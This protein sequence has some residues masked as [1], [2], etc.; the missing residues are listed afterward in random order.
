M[1]SNFYRLMGLSL[2]FVATVSTAVPTI[3]HWQTSNG[4]SVYFV[5]TTG[6]PILD[7]QLLF[8]A[9]SVRDDAKSGIAALT[10][11]LLDQ[12]A[13]RKSA[14]D[15]A[16]ALESVGAQLGV[17]TSRD[18]TSI[19]FRSL[20]DTESLKKS[21]AILKKVVNEPDF[22][23][24]DFQREKNR[25][26]LTIAKREESPG[27]LAQLALYKEIFKGHGYA[28]AV[29]GN[30]RTVSQLTADDLK[31]FYDDYYVAQNLKVILVGGVSNE[32]AKDM[33]EDL[34][35]RLPLGEKAATIADVV[36]LKKGKTI[37]REY[38]SQQTHI[39]YSLPVLK[40]NDADYFA[41]YMGNHI[42]GGSGFSSR[43]VKE[44]REQRGLAYSAY[45]Y[46]HPMVEKGPFLVGLQTRNEKVQEATDAIK[47]TLS[48]FIENGPTEEEL[49]A[50]K[51]NLVGG[52]ALKLDSNKK[53]LANV[54][55]I[56]ASGAPLNY[57][58]E[59]MGK[60]KA[61]TRK[62]V[63]DAFERRVVMDKMVMVTV[64]KTVVNQDDGK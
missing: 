8:D 24:V 40:H 17:S 13:A 15:I 39:M 4:V 47:S 41:L 51:K 49:V 30:K 36:D 16:E 11:V 18:F 14:Q 53:L 1:R 58:N 25:T 50:A 60:V 6:L 3:Q 33:V 20:T 38:S 21:W 45:S 64:G 9:G 26:L 43:I 52:F 35:G 23:E 31:R 46:F 19:S 37:H 63:T 2:L 29:Q 32:R 55:G 22:P 34:I 54:A 57:L 42:L 12:S 5:P 28:N 44:I 7:A 48:D 10:S 62:Q 56:V 27:T 61:V 59:Y